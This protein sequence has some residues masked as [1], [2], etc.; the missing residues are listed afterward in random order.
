MVKGMLE[1]P[2]KAL[3]LGNLRRPRQCCQLLLLSGQRI[4]FFF[5]FFFSFLLT[6]G[7]SDVLYEGVYDE[8]G[9]EEQQ[10][11]CGV[12]GRCPRHQRGPHGDVRGS[13]L[14]SYFQE[15]SAG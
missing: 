13:S 6:F 8:V 2:E 14:V 12:R 4:F 3:K 7:I 9:Y 11:G 5:F 10:Q 15:S 1:M